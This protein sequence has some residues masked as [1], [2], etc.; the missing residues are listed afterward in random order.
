MI[1]Y[2]QEALKQG[3]KAM[4]VSICQRTLQLVVTRSGV[5]RR[6]RVW[7]SLGVVLQVMHNPLST[8]HYVYSNPPFL[9]MSSSA[10]SFMAL[11]TSNMAFT[12]EGVRTLVEP[13]NVC[14]KYWTTF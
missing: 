1:G 8:I 2:I 12:L 14:P 7:I 10:D 13:Y 4:P 11:G 9:K 5:E 3:L 6:L